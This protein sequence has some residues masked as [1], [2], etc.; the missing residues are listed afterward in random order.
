MVRKKTTTKTTAKKAPAKK[1]SSGVSKTT[2]KT[3]R[4][5]PAKSKADGERK[6]KA[7]EI[8]KNKKKAAVLDE[9]ERNNFHITN[10]CKKIGIE[11]KT[12]YNWLEADQDFAEKYLAIQEEDL[13]NSELTLRRLRDGVPKVDEDGNFKGWEIRPDVLAVMF[14]LK[15][16]GKGRGYIERQEITGKDGSSLDVKVQVVGAN[17]EDLNL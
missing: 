8:A 15:T 2:R 16:K 11:R 7:N 12:F 3:T 14:H 9:L 5:A 17:D 6:L 10:A 1:A 13:D 4:R